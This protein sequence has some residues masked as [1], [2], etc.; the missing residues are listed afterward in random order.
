MDTQIHQ[1]RRCSGIEQT[2]HGTGTETVLSRRIALNMNAKTLVTATLVVS[3]L[4]NTGISSTTSMIASY[5][6]IGQT[7]VSQAKGESDR[8][9]SDELLRKARESL[10]RGDLNA[11]NRSLQEAEKLKVRYNGLLQ[12]FGD[13][14]QKLRK[15]LEKAF[16]GELPPIESAPPGNAPQAISSGLQ[17]TARQMPVPIQGQLMNGATANTGRAAPYPTNLTP[18]TVG[19]PNGNVSA[20]SLKQKSLQLL[21]QSRVAMQ[22]GDVAAARRYA[23]QAHDLRVPDSAYLANEPIPWKVLLELDRAQQQMAASQNP[24]PSEVVQA[25]F[26]NSFGQNNVAQVA[27]QISVNS[28]DFADPFVNDPPSPPTETNNGLQ[29]LKD[30]EEALKNQDHE[31]ARGL[32]IQAW[33][34][35]GQ[36]DPASRQRLQDHLQLMRVKDRALPEPERLTNGEQAIVRRF[37]SE[38]SRE[39]AAVERTLR[40]DPKGAWDRLKALH[41][42]VSDAE[43]PASARQTLTARIEKSLDSTEEYIRRNRVRIEQDEKNR[44][45]IAQIDRDRQHRM[46]VE[47]KLAEL[48]DEHNML[49]NQQRYAEAMVVA[50]KASQLAPNRP[51]VETMTWKSRFAERLS[52]EMSIRDRTQQGVELALRQTSK[53]AIPYDE[54]NLLEFPEDGDVQYWEALSDRRRKRVEGQSRRLS[55]TELQIQRALREK[56]RVSYSEVPLGQVL[57]GL[58]DLAGVSIYLDPNALQFEGIT[59]NMPVSINLNQEIMLMSALNLILEP[60][61]LTYVVQD[62]VLKITSREISNKKTEFRTYDVADLVVAIPN[63][64]SS[65]DD[66]MSGALRESFNAQRPLAMI[67][68]NITSTPL[69]PPLSNN[70]QINKDVLTQMH[71]PGMMATSSGNSA[72]PGFGPGGMGGAA[73]ADFDTLIELITATISPDSWED[74]GGEGSIQGYPTNLSLVVSNTQDVHEQIADLLDQLRQLQDLQVTIEVR[75]I[76]LNDNFFEQ[77]GIDFDFDID[78]N[79]TE[80]PDDDSGSSVTVGLDPNGNLTTDLDLQFQQNNFATARPAFGGF[81]P[82]AASTFGFAILSDIEAFFLIEAASGDSRTNVLQAPKVTLFNGQQATVSDQSQRPFVTSVTPVVGDFA[83]AQQPIILVL[84]EGTRLTVQAVVSPDRRFVRLTLVPFFSE[85]G[86][87]ETFQFEGRRS[88]TTGTAAVDP[89]DGTTT[90]QNDSEDFIEGTTVQLPQFAFTSVSTTVSVPDGGTILLGGIKRLSE[91]RNERAVPMLGKIPYINRLFKNVGI[92]RT[93]QSL[94]MMVT[95]RIIIQ[96]EEEERLGISLP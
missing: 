20:G 67:N 42:R 3:V 55:E 32:F 5:V 53:A 58:G 56:V 40:Q 92:G 31:Q 39:Q 60:F 23:Q 9:R 66:G 95:P 12:R 22:R 16:G 76:T 41:E 91:G 54:R 80:L 77:I 49:M 81:S 93:T 74:V 65:Y 52:V 21:T 86:N 2:I 11:A 82:D 17:Q 68:G 45:V 15:D 36:L 25:G 69:A 1:G 47:Q 51:I 4:T 44:A 61:G 64:P 63:F 28:D 94:M 73:Q 18:Q 79:A 96:E 70:D 90:V 57:D 8:Q 34:Y 35:E 37:V 13:T 48:V 87:V 33:E 19:Q 29:L 85:I 78:D 6:Q 62:E 71:S 30:G 89:T 43:I 75:F 38:I 88:S 7:A 26:D 27:A 83:A 14:P 59:S 24:A 46:D 84:N 50:K 10:N 72:I